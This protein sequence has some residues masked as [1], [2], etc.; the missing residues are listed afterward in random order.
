ML[1]H[2]V[3]DVPLEFSQVLAS[4]DVCLSLEGQGVM[5]AGELRALVD[6]SEA[7]V[8]GLDRDAFPNLLG[9]GL[10]GVGSGGQLHSDPVFG[11]LDLVLGLLAEVAS[12]L[13]QLYVSSF[14]GGHLGVGSIELVTADFVEL[15]KVSLSLSLV[16]YLASY[17]GGGRR[18]LHVLHGPSSI[19]DLEEVAGC[20]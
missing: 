17:P 3:G 18:N 5:E 16:S 12:S 7:D 6:L 14:D 9:E 20:L 15:P 11:D 10:V 1:G 4:G 2:P 19:G 13:Q 8:G